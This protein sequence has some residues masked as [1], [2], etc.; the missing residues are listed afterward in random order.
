MYSYEILDYNMLWFIF[1]VIGF[2]AKTYE[3]VTDYHEEDWFY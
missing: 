2:L 3:T 1:Y